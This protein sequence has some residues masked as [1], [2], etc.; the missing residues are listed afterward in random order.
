AAERLFNLPMKSV[1]GLELGQLPIPQ[2]LRKSLG[3]KFKT[4]IDDLKQISVPGNGLRSKELGGRV[5]ITI[6][7][8]ARD[9]S[10]RGA[11]VMF[12]AAGNKTESSGKPANPRSG[13]SSRP[14]TKRKR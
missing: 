7:P 10:A 1:V 14:S 9:G 6:T 2:A 5:E 13:R 4:A 8:L 11:L 12:G 3:A